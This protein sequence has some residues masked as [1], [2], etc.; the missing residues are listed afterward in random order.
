[1]SARL[2]ARRRASLTALVLAALAVLLAVLGSP[3]PAAA[4]EGATWRL[5]LVLPP[6]VEGLPEATTPI[7]LGRIGDVEFWAPNRGL[8]I[9]AGNP[10]TIPPGVW[11][12]DGV[13]WHELA[14]VCG[15][16]EGRIA[17]AGP[18][19]F[20][21]VSDGRPGQALVE[22]SEP[23]LAD[24]TL[25]HFSSGAVAGSYASLAF[26]PDSYQVMHGAACLSA[27]DCWF[28]GE[29]L[30]AGQV[31][32][33]HL[34]WDG[35]TLSA[36][37]NPQG[38]AVLDLRQF[39]RRLYES[40]RVTG[41]DITS[42]PESEI[43][44]SVLHAIAPT[45]VSPTFTLLH[46]ESAAGQ[47]LPSYRPGEFPTGLD[48]LQLS[49]DAEAVWGAA[50][51]VSPAPEGSAPGEV[52]ILRQSGGVWSQVL[53]P[54]SGPEGGNP[55]TKSVTGEHEGSNEVVRSIAALPGSEAAWLALDT[56]SDAERP[57]PIAHAL[58]A[59]ISAEGTVS[60][61]Q[62][63]PSPQEE[64][65][66]IGPKGGAER[67]SCPAA[68]DC[69]LPT[70]QGWLFHLAN[71][72]T[73][74]LPRD[75]DP[76]FK[77]PITFRPK[78]QGVPTIVP[79]APPVDDS[80]LP[81]EQPSSLPPE[82]SS[83]QPEARI[84]VPLLSHVRSRLVRGTTL[85]LSFHLAVK[86]RLRLIAKRR[87]SVVASTPRKTLAAG[88]RRLML[89]LS[90]KRWPTRLDLQSHALGPLP[91]VSTRS[92]NVGTVSTQARFG[93]GVGALGGWDALP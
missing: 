91:T 92:P 35:S 72:S 25:C 45:G 54:G 88:N 44:P 11:A 93:S 84:P 6:A 78:D 19:E 2:P 86:A 50:N 28:A 63:L 29:N 73:R 9:T 83:R 42:P 30:P 87:G 13:S 71:A 24:N 1:M 90:R 62:T 4:E 66:G 39:A 7:G 67:I 60:E 53:G 69:W 12:Y 41:S 64:A 55:F 18:E 57:S 37:P 74:H 32:S 56:K 49:A 3:S 36:R 10:P 20:W 65:E 34:H 47:P 43:E 31:G 27:A 79:D 22:G 14:N 17:W 51:P 48:Y 80:G 38:R 61:Q 52:T 46:P 75:T 81:G 68:N 77:G 76:N 82:T 59:R 70:P 89:V 23:P 58:I 21:T 5:E 33:F 16:T 85:E 40:V 8:L 26:R 15:A